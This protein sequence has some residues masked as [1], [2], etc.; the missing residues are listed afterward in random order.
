[1]LAVLAACTVP[2]GPAIRALSMFDGAAVAQG[3]DDYCIDPGVS[4]PA[5]G[6]A[7]L[8]PCPI[9]SD[10]TAVPDLEALL[11]LQLGAAGSAGV[12]GSEP[13][14]EGLLRSTAGFRL[15]SDTGTAEGVTVLS[16]ATDDGVVYVRMT[17]A[18]NPPATG[19]DPVALRAFVDVGGRFSTVTL[20]AFSRAPLTDVQERTLLDQAIRV[21]IAVNSPN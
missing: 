1:M 16:T 4:R 3:P 2:Q 6:F 14:L 10:E 8:V 11:T 18:A 7:V 12:T 13:A 9:V 19:I 17:D 21:L 20:R 5:T 15:L